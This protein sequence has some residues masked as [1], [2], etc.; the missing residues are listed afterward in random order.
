MLG[1]MELII[2]GVVLVV[3]VFAPFLFAF[4]RA[5]FRHPLLMAIPVSIAVFLVVAL[6]AGFTGVN[7]L[8]I[9]AIIAIAAIVFGFSQSVIRTSENKSDAASRKAFSA[10]NEASTWD[11]AQSAD[12]SQDVSGQVTGR[13][14]D[15]DIEASSSKLAEAKAKEAEGL[16]KVGLNIANHHEAE[17]SNALS[18][19]KRET[20]R[21]DA[22]PVSSR[23]KSRTSDTELS[24]RPSR[25]KKALAKRTE[26]FEIVAFFAMVVSLMLLG[27]LFQGIITPTQT[28]KYQFDVNRG[29]SVEQ[30]A[31]DSTKFDQRDKA[32]LERNKISEGSD[33]LKLLGEVKGEMELGARRQQ[34][35][36]AEQAPPEM[37][38]PVKEM[39]GNLG[40][41]R[42]VLEVL[43]KMTPEQRQEALRLA[44]GL[45]QQMG[46]DRIVGLARCVAAFSRGVTHGWVN[47]I[48][49]FVGIGGT[50]KEIEFIGQLE[51]I[52]VQEFHPYRP[53]DPW[54]ERLLLQAIE[55]LPWVF[56][57]G[58]LIFLGY[59]WKARYS[60]MKHAERPK[61]QPFEAQF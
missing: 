38:T 32:I 55:M 31:Q 42:Y 51:E 33:V 12:L 58:A 21:H 13:K 56:V 11:E 36:Y 37:V 26:T 61:T 6:V 24:K 17:H 30:E 7:A 48:M 50:A 27:V 44:P 60:Q 47:P 4:A 39:L 19:Q 40:N 9:L 52:A 10:S 20:D 16:A 2:A 1:T 49:E 57:I 29:G 46:D 28:G 45:A 35:A 59:R 43:R 8:A 54:H 53:G 15:T 41:R 5:G 34:R 22:I 3:L 23:P 18:T 14:H 25:P